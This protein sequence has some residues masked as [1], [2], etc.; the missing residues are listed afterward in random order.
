MAVLGWVTT[1]LTLFAFQLLMGMIDKHQTKCLLNQR[2]QTGIKHRHQASE[3]AS[4]I[5]KITWT[6]IKHQ[7]NIEQASSIRKINRHQASEKYLEANRFFMLVFFV[8]SVKKRI[9]K[10]MFL[11]LCGHLIPEKVSVFENLRKA[12]ESSSPAWAAHD[13]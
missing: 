13:T 5:R 11:V 8:V 2:R 9:T 10:K 12:L 6:G 3:Q 1:S 7:K 4:S